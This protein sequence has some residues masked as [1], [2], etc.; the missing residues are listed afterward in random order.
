MHSFKQFSS[1]N[2]LLFHASCCYSWMTG[3]CVGFDIKET[4]GRIT[5][6]TKR[7]TVDQIC[8]QIHQGV[9]N[10]QQRQTWKLT[11]SQIINTKT[12]ES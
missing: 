8:R 9:R 10:T 4:H 12:I 11:W 6:R 5:G 3:Y 7:R 2:T 1:V